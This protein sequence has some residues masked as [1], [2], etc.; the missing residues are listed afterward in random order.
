MANSNEYMADYMNRRYHLRRLEAIALLGSKCARCG[1]VEDLEFDHID[2]ETKTAPISRLFSRGRER[3]L[4]ELKLCQLLCNSCHKEK[5]FIEEGIP[6][7][8]GLSG[9]KGCSCIPCKARK[10]QYMRDYYE[11]TRH[12]DIYK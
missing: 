10:A 5:T 11:R 2:P 1:A 9:K 12:N 4:E 6:H 3:F 7:G 8:G